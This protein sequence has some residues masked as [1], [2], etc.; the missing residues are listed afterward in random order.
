MLRRR[1]VLVGLLAK[2]AISKMSLGEEIAQITIFNQYGLPYLPVMVMNT[3]KLVETAAQKVGLPNLKI[4]YR[5]LGGTSSLVDALIS[6]Q[7]HFGVAGAPSLATLWDKTV[8]TAHE[9]GGLGAA[10]WMP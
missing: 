4:D 5:T 1:D 3:L 6:G 10:P 9:V 7:M 2:P 8:G